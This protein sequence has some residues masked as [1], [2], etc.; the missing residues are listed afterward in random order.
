[1]AASVRM[2]ST[3]TPCTSTEASGLPSTS[4]TMRP[5]RVAL[6]QL[7]PRVGDLAR[8]VGAL[9]VCGG[10]RLGLANPQDL[11]GDIEPEVVKR[12]ECRRPAE[13]AELDAIDRDV[14]AFAFA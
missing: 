8:K 7:N 11:L 5:M 1:M 13:F 9:V 3:G 4:S 12:A 6:A 10:L 2:T 14:F